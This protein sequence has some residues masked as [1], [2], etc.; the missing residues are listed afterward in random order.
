MGVDEPSTGSSPLNNLFK[1]SR[2]RFSS[3]NPKEFTVNRCT[4]TRLQFKAFIPKC[5]TLWQQSAPTQWPHRVLMH[6]VLFLSTLIWHSHLSLLPRWLGG[7][8]LVSFISGQ[9]IW[10]GLLPVCNAASSPA[11]V[12]VF[13]LKKGCWTSG[14][15]WNSG[16]WIPQAVSSELKI[17]SQTQSEFH[18]PLKNI[19]CISPNARVVEE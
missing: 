9:D 14:F 17:S 18:K 16:M 4:T 6:I 19:Y 3:L 2:S 10:D 8:A 15:M 1:N 12:M 11:S 7:G 5:K 13:F